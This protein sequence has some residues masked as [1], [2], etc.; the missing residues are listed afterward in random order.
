MSTPIVVYIQCD[1]QARQAQPADAIGFA[2]A[3]LFFTPAIWSRARV[4][5]GPMIVLPI[6]SS[7]THEEAP[8]EPGGGNSGDPPPPTS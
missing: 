8:T 6:A 1:D 4:A 5:N 7:P 3:G 2:G